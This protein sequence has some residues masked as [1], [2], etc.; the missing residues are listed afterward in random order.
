MEK[1]RL[2]QSDL[3]F[4]P[5]MLGGNVFGWTADEAT[6]HR[7][8][9]A[10]VAACYRRPKFAL[11]LSW[12]AVHEATTY[13]EH[14]VDIGRRTAVERLAH[15]LLEIHARL[16]LVGEYRDVFV[17]DGDLLRLKERRC[18]YDNLLIPT[19]LCIPV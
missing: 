5:L 1:R 16:L 19:A 12:L 10:F 2:G 14:V 7:V 6:S 13:A 9:D 4:A 8:L 15:F 3:H 11:A 18:V 17:R